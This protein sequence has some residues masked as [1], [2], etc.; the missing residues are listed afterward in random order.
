MR[1]HVLD[2]VYVS[3]SVHVPALQYMYSRVWYGMVWVQRVLLLIRC[4]LG[5]SERRTFPE[6]LRSQLHVGWGETLD[7]VNIPRC[8]N[9]HATEQH[10][11][12]TA[13]YT[14][15]GLWPCA[16]DA[17]TSCTLGLLMALSFNSNRFSSSK[18]S[19]FVTAI[20]LTQK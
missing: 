15:V 5:A 19:S 11:S 14:C 10:A 18:D 1:M 13:R 8:D 3:E 4:R 6:I 12:L 7:N 20:L 16:R 9:P 17:P 2:R